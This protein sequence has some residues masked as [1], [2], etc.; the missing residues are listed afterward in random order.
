MNLASGGDLLAYWQRKHTKTSM[1]YSKSLKFA[2]L[3]VI[4]KQTLQ[5][6]RD[7]HAAGLI[8]R[9]IKPENIMLANEVIN[10]NKKQVMIGEF[11]FLVSGTR[12]RDGLIWGPKK[13]ASGTHEF[14]PPEVS[15][16][17]R[18]DIW[19]LGWTLLLLYKEKDTLYEHISTDG[20]KLNMEKLDTFLGEIANIAA[21]ASAQDVE[22]VSL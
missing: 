4:A 1:P 5:G 19:A 18:M 21:S 9:D 2:E 14:I 17:D 7:L 8:H 22:K 16:T 13:L 6:L 11:G 15:Q 10:I 12:G 3:Q 20:K